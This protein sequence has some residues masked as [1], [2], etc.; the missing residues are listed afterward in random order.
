[1]WHHTHAQDRLVY[2]RSPYLRMQY[3]SI[4]SGLAPVLCD[5]T[6][7]SALVRQSSVMVSALS[8]MCWPLRVERWFCTCGLRQSQSA[9]HNTSLLTHMF[10][11]HKFT[12]V[13][14]RVA[15]FMVVRSISSIPEE[16]LRVKLSLRRPRASQGLFDMYL[17]G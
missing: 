4:C 11:L 8:V 9:L 7:L 5:L 13:L 10:P 16:S 12:A 3:P 6:R 17:S 14:P 2:S 15:F 1:M